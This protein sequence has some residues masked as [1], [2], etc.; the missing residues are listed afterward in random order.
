MCRIEFNL[1]STRYGFMI[2]R[3]HRRFWQQAGPDGILMIAARPFALDRSQ[4]IF[5]SIFRQREWVAPISRVP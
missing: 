5:H 3:P 1:S 2:I 4:Y